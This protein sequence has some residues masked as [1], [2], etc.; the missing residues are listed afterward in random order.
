M[1]R[2]LKRLTGI[3]FA[4]ILASVFSPAFSA[5]PILLDGTWGEDFEIG[6]ISGWESYPA[7]EDT[8]YDYTILPGR[9]HDRYDLQGFVGSGEFFY[10]V[11]LAPPTT[12]NTT[13]LLRA[14]RPNSASPQLVGATVKLN[15][16]CVAPTSEINFDYW[17]KNISEPSGIEV[18]IAGGDGKRYTYPLTIQT[19]QWR[20][21]TVKLA[22]MRSGTLAP[23]AGIAIQ[24][25]AIVAGFAKGDASSYI[26][27]AL[28]NVT[29]G[30]RAQ[31]GFSPS[32]PP[33]RGF[34]HWPILFANTHYHPGDT[35][36][37]ATK[38]STTLTAVTAKLQNFD[39]ETVLGPVNLASSGG[40]WTGTLGAFKTTDVP[41]PYMIV[42]EG[43]D[44]A[45]KVARSD[46]R[47]WLL[48][49]VA[50]GTHPRLLF[51]AVDIPNLKARRTSPDGQAGWSTIQSK[52]S[53]GRSTTVPTNSVN[54]FFPKDYLVP[55]QTAYNSWTSA[56]TGPEQAI[57]YNAFVYAISDDA[58]AGQYA[59]DG[60]VNMAAWDTWNHPWFEGQGRYAYYPIGRA[61]QSLAFAYDTVH[62]LLSEPERT[63]IRHGIMKNGVIPAW[64][65]YFRDNRIASDTSN[66]INHSCSGAIEALA[67]MD[68]ELDGA[69][70]VD[71]DI[72]FAGLAEKTFEHARHTLHA[73]AAWGEDFSYQDYSQQG[74]QP[75]LAALENVYG[76]TD[77]ARSLY[78][79]TGHIFPVYASFNNGLTL[80]PMGD[81]HEGHTQSNTWLWFAA[82]ANDPT[83]QWWVNV[84]ANKNKWED[85]LWRNTMLPE[86]SPAQAGWL[87][88]RVFPDKG[89]V[90]FRSGWGTNDVVLVYRGGPNYNH[91]HVDQ[92]NFVMAVGSEQLI[93]EA[94]CGSYYYQDPYFW[95]Y[96]TQPGG[97]NVILV[98]GNPESQATGDFTSEVKALNNYAKTDRTIL[99]GPTN[100]L[101]SQ[102]GQLYRGALSE[103]TR[104]I[105]FLDPGW[106]VL[107]DRI[108]SAADPHQYV[109]QLFP[110]SKNA[111]TINAA[112]QATIAGSSGS[113]KINVVGGAGTQLRIADKPMPIADYINKAYKERAALQLVN[114]AKSMQQDYVVAL[115]PMQAGSPTVT[116]SDASG[117]GYKGARLV[118]ADRES[119]V[120]IGAGIQGSISTDGLSASSTAIAGR[121]TSA[122]FELATRGSV[123][124]MEFFVSDKALNAGVDRTA[125][126][127][128]T[129]YFNAPQAATV[130]VTTAGGAQKL[131][132]VPAGNS[133]FVVDSTAS[134]GAGNMMK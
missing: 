94:G 71:W 63:A 67:A 58:N 103:W 11:D 48:K 61:T 107:C 87:K 133:S 28:D 119:L 115:I 2:K 64:K 113:V 59:R 33:A 110:P 1:A 6:T 112:T 105:Y 70:A 5:E 130:R 93:S 126:T 131:L 124:G 39:G 117:A 73:D 98:D 88:S 13:Y 49:A 123:G 90:V 129:W 35:I 85:F 16:A 51:S 21:A 45:G 32:Q 84:V 106:V 99:A 128:E 10:P 132:Q 55:D 27:L 38:T 104:R 12:P 127:N 125:T 14:Y 41:G 25:I 108:Q 7:F 8:G 31:A 74:C 3:L 17:L 4:L 53:S 95:S 69:D 20:H 109:W 30:C 80:L 29:L 92:G 111:L 46:V 22:D 76:V 121:V 65:E 15:N 122:A 91:T 86:Q 34:K 118:A 24:A 26:Y 56:L 68:G 66:W 120:V 44:P 116:V 101:A 114:T 83:Y 89:N 47:V 81:S 37:L 100:F 52:A 72:Y 102:L 79:T 77:V 75:M 9:Y 50:A 62:G 36:S 43:T 18:Q 54:R 78:Y 82:K 96:F 97:H 23:P 19:G 40:Q 134:T 57:F 60:L 42:F